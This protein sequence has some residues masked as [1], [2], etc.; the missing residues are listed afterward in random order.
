MVVLETYLSAL[1][2]R[3]LHELPKGLQLIY[4]EA[5][6]YVD[7]ETDDSKKLLA[8]KVSVHVYVQVTCK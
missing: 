5:S 4:S 6:G 7:D 2:R 8:A 3:E 1:A